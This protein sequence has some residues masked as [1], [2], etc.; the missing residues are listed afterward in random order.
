MLIAWLMIS[1]VQF[2]TFKRYTRKKASGYYVLGLAI[3]VLCIIGLLRGY[4][5]LFLGMG[6]YI[7]ISV[8]WHVVSKLIHAYERA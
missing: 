7:F 1:R 4:P 8:V 5:L 2:P 3:I 6:S